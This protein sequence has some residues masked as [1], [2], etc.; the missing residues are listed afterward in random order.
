MVIP[1]KYDFYADT[2]ED[3]IVAKNYNKRLASDVTYLPQ[4]LN[5]GGDSFPCL[6][7]PTTQCISHLANVHSMIHHLPSTRDSPSSIADLKADL[8]WLLSNLP[9][10]RTHRKAQALKKSKNAH[11]TIT[12]NQE[13]DPNDIARLEVAAA[14]APKKTVFTISGKGLPIEVESWKFNEFAYGSS[15][16]F[17]CRARGLFL[18]GNAI[19]TRGYD[20][21]F[22]VNEVPATRLEN[23]Q[24]LKGPFT[25]STKE[26][27][28]IIFLSGL[29]DGTLLVCSKH[30]T[31]DDSDPKVVHFARGRA[32]VYRQLEKHG[33]S[34]EDLAKELY[35]LNVTAVC[36]LCDDDFEEHILEYPKEL[37][38]LYLH[39]L[40]FNTREFRTYPM[41]M[42]QQFASEWGFRGIDYTEFAEFPQLWD[43][44][45]NCAKSGTHNG[46]SIEGFVVRARTPDDKDFLFK[47]KF[48]EPYLLYR[49]M[50]EVTTQYINSIQ[51]EVVVSKKK[52]KRQQQIGAR[53]AIKILLDSGSHSSYVTHIA[54]RQTKHRFI[55]YEYLKFVEV[56]FFN[57][58]ELMPE[59]SLNHGIIR[60]RK[61]FLEHYGV[62][63][64]ISLLSL[65]NDSRLSQ[66][67]SQLLTK[68][69]FKYCIVPIATIGCGKTTTFQTLTGLFPKWAHVQNDDAKSATVFLQG[70]ME[71][72]ENSD[73]VF[74]DKNNSYVQD[75][76]RIFDTVTREQAKYVLPD[77]AIRFI[78]LNFVKHGITDHLK[79]V[80]TQRVL[81]RGDRHQ[82]IKSESNKEG[83]LQAIDA[84]FRGLIAPKLKDDAENDKYVRPGT[85]YWLPD[86]NFDLVIDMDVDGDLSL[87]NAMRIV[88][89]LRE[90]FPEFEKLPLIPDKAWQESFEKAK[91]YVPLTTKTIKK[92][93]LPERRPE[94]FG[95]RILDHD[96]LVSEIEKVISADPTWSSL[97]LLHRVQE[98]F[99][100]TLAHAAAKLRSAADKEIWDHLGRVFNSAAMKKKALPGEYKDCAFDVDVNVTKLVVVK[101]TLVT[102]QVLLGA[103][104]K[105]G[106]VENL[107][108]RTSN[109]FS[110]I[111]VGTCG[112]SIP[113]VMS[114]NILEE[115]HARYDDFGPGRY[116]L[117][118]HE[119]LVFDL[120]LSLPAQRTYIKFSGSSI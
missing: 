56:E 51:D 68:S 85:D 107:Q 81:D 105:E 65:D 75:R 71:L 23:L 96:N 94:Y 9:R 111:T 50:R 84:F 100:V 86:S 7:D 79:E 95:I 3:R 97:K 11:S 33:K 120:L 18:S 101:D 115:L 104:S 17:P 38:G 66:Q 12:D 92:A 109:K 57:N 73:V 55:L 34:A 114:N 91:A 110:H 113:Q 16:P 10:A 30:S 90:R 2:T 27:G 69:T 64:G 21:F 83:A 74:I 89:V 26:N 63:E 29:E 116:E 49:S 108:V 15:K 31:G 54:L 67:F 37:A 39:G 22:N 72:L 112:P 25:L 19:V 8:E 46:R 103:I 48:E 61:K 32:E 35:D 118:R 28:C 78:G 119:A 40:N 87:Q 52:A 42:T 24:R 77:T 20:K 5:T 62:S 106:K 36:E 47:F 93:Q 13:L 117:S 43:F 88:E 102:L 60:V 14:I 45:E 59:Y 99:H 80:T 44:M 6:C 41:E 1:Q 82:A 70:I 4:K 98:K 76:Q 53:D 58:P